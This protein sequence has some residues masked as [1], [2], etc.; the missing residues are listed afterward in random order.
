[1]RFTGREKELFHRQREIEQSAGIELWIGGKC[2]WD[3]Y[4]QSQ[5]DLA[6]VNPEYKT[7]LE[8]RAVISRKRYEHKEAQHK[9]VNDL[10]VELQSVIHINSLTDEQKVALRVAVELMW[11]CK[12]GVV[13]RA[14]K[15][16]KKEAAKNAPSFR[17]ASWQSK[18]KPK[19]VGA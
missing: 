8:E 2:D 5:N 19:A 6:A 18:R 11:G 15:R 13:V 4:E 3:K 9:R 10:R 16:A 14:E 12:D 7:L 1:M 17:P